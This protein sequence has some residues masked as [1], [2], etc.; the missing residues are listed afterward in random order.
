MQNSNRVQKITKS[1][2]P[3]KKSQWDT[4][5][6]KESE[7]NRRKARKARHYSDVA[8]TRCKL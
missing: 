6:R 1:N 5:E 2:K 7:I 8:A 4:I 3:A